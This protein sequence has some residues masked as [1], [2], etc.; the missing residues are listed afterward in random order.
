LCSGSGMGV[1]IQLHALA[2]VLPCCLECSLQKQLNCSYLRK[3]AYAK[4]VRSTP[5]Q[6]QA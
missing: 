5:S 1:A 3:T 2:S 6:E 4:K